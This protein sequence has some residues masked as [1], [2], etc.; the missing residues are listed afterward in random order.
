[1]G[2]PAQRAFDAP[3]GPLRLGADDEALRFLLF[4]TPEGDGPAESAGAAAILDESCRQL[5][6]Y[7]EGRLQNFEL[8]VDPEGTAFQRRVWLAL[9]DIPYA[10]TISYAELALRLGAP[11]ATRAV[12]AAN[13]AN[14]ISIILPCHRVVGSDG[15]LVGYGGGLEVKQWLLEH[16][17][18]R[19]RAL[20]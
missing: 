1:M 11:R 5:E 2:D 4:G 14:P 16:E 3:F 10:T 13:G 6:R 18:A 17:G 20:F 9:R 15:R 8:P 12:G 19:S 7:F